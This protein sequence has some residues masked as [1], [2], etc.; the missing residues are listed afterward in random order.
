MEQIWERRVRRQERRRTVARAVT[1][2]VAM[3]LACAAWVGVL[4]VLLHL[5]EILGHAT[6]AAVR[7]YNE[8]VR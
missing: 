5:P 1:L 2:V 8:S 6:G 7:A 4:Y 3:T